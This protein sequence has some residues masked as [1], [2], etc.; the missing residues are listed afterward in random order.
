M[1]EPKAPSYMHADAPPQRWPSARSRET[2]LADE[3]VRVPAGWYPDPLGLPQLRWWDNHA[4]TEH[5][6]DARQPMVAQENTGPRLAFADDIDESGSYGAQGYGEQ[7]YGQAYQQEHS[8]DI[9]YDLGAYG[10]QFTVDQ[11]QQPATD[12]AG[13][14]AEQ[15]TPFEFSD[16]VLSLEAPVRDEVQTDEP[17]PAAR[18]AANGYVSEAPTSFAYDL[19]T[20]FDDLLGAQTAPRTAYGAMA[21]ST[22]GYSADGRQDLG[23]SPR[24][25]QQQVS[26]NDLPVSTGP[27][28]AIALMPLLMLVAGLLY[29]L[30]GSGFLPVVGLVIVLGVPYLATIVLAFFDRKQLIAAGYEHTAHWAWAF[31]TA[32]VY[33]IARFAAVVRETGRG[34][35]PL[36][37]WTALGVLLA[38]S[39]V[40][41]PGLIIALAPAQF[42]Q[43]AEAS[44]ESSA[45]S[46]GTTLTASCPTTPPLLVGQSFECSVNNGKRTWQVPVSLQRANG[47]IVWRVDDWNTYIGNS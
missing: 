10:S 23:Y 33:L 39:V 38:G 24:Y 2:E 14:R 29:L 19:G 47:W 41:V 17:S 35:G 27:A 37:T 34:F 12:G 6:S 31:L 42:A 21:D 22:P 46:L 40:A 13:T 8:A 3:D 11:S 5:T 30:A 16:P 32:P 44:V 25:L 26:S 1:G 4:W 28:W 15:D 43:Q 36:M 7:G 45:A 20:R 18:I 9:I